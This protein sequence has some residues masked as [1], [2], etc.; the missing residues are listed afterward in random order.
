MTTGTFTSSSHVKRMPDTNRPAR[1]RLTRRAPLRPE[2]RARRR[3]DAP[4]H[5]LAQNA[6]AHGRAHR[7]W[8][9]AIAFMITGLLLLSIP[10]RACAPDASDRLRAMLACPHDLCGR[11]YDVQ[12]SIA[13]DTRRSCG[14]V[15]SIAGRIQTT[16]GANGVVVFG[17]VHD[18][19]A[20]H[21]LRAEVLSV[22]LASEGAAL[23]F[24]HLRPEQ[25]PA[26]DAFMAKDLK[27]RG[28]ADDLLRA[29]DWDKSGWPQAGLFKPL[30]DAALA[31]RRSI[32]P[33]DPPRSL[34]RKAAKEGATALPEAE[35]TRLKLDTPLPEKLQSALVDELENSHCG[36]MPR[37]AFTNMAFAQRYRDAHLA[38]A[39]A[40]AADAHGSAVLLAGN[41][42]ARTDRGVP[43]YL[44]QMAP[45]RKIVSVLLIE[46]E[47]GK[48]VAEA[49]VPRDP[50]GKPAADYIVFTPR[51]ERPD[52][53]TEMR[54][55]FQSKAK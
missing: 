33:G 54:R 2:G 19:P 32:L 15:G 43:Y 12:S 6:A 7:A 3:A 39:V 16:V 29:L 41:G 20:H 26:L 38:A 40:S 52:P 9:I 14:V 36:L 8:R 13:V 48:T 46:V 45:G 53:C 44:R 1:A 4:A 49:Y 50:D 5:V 28:T 10:A 30:F 27:E 51:V 42:H 31:S 24:E 25:R 37:S 47:D 17:E 35:R 22:H 23:V 21:Q 11:I 18:N 34:I 55:Q